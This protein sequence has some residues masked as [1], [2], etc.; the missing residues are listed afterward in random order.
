MWLSNETLKIAKKF[1]M[2]FGI[3]HSPSYVDNSMT[4]KMFKIDQC[5]TVENYC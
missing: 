4:T 1:T 5:G 2:P 3:N